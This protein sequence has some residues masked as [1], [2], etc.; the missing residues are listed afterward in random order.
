MSKAHS[1]GLNRSGMEK[2]YTIPEVAAKCV[3]ELLSSVN[4][5]E[6]D[7]IVEPSAGNGSFIPFITPL[8]KRHLFIDIDPDHPE[9]IKGDFLD[10][11][12][13]CSHGYRIH[14]V[15]N[16]P[17]GRQSSLACKFIKKACSFADTVAF[18]LPRSFSKESMKRRVPVH[19]H[20]VHEHSV[21][22]DAFSVNGMKHNVPCVFQIWSR[23]TCPRA[24]PNKEKPIGFRFVGKDDLHDFSVRRVGVKAGAVSSHTEGHSENSHYFIS[25]D[26]QLDSHTIDR[27][28]SLSIE[29]KDMTVGPR[30]ISKGELIVA[31]NKELANSG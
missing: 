6:D 25:F 19:F 8:S 10:I 16:P 17:F 31:F 21:A 30:S 5:S 22:D 15:G 12:P 26:T 3:A 24:V 23:Q 2:F 1:T 28:G 14:V 11:E 9:V 29:G 13:P 4:I 20:L 7:T 27:L 18:V